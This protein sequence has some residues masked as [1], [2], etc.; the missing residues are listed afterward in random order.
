MPKKQEVEKNKFRAGHKLRVDH[1]IV[2]KKIN[3]SLELSIKDGSAYAA[4]AGFG[5]SYLAPFALAL[6][7]TASQVGILHAIIWIVPSIIQLKASSL[8]RKYSRKRIVTKAVTAEILL[9]IP[10]ILTGLAFYLGF[11]KASWI[12]IGLSGAIYATT[13]IM[14]PIWFSWI[15]SLA[16]ENARGKYFSKRNRISGFV[17]VITMI[18]AALVLDFMKKT[19]ELAGRQLE[20]TLIG[21]AILFSLAILSR[22][23]SLITLKKQYEPRFKLRKKD[24][25]PLREFLKNCTKNSFGKFTIFRA[26]VSF[27]VGIAGPFWTVYMLKDLG[28]PYIWYIAVMSSTIIFRLIFLPALGKISDKF[29]NVNL[30]RISTGAISLVPILWI[31]SIFIPTGLI[32]KLYLIFFVQMISGFGWAGYDLAVNNYVFD[33]VNSQRRSFGMSY[34]TL[35]VGVST[36][37]GA[38]V[39]SGLATLNIQFMNTILFIFAISAVLRILSAIFATRLLHEVRHVKK[40]RYEYLIKEFHPMRGVN[41]EVH[42]LEHIIKKNVHY[43]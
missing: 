43:A 8:L 31:A 41:R 35:F 9:W 33:A 34:M 27:S 20:Y 17:G 22:T 37:I 7:A 23:Y 14:Y 40:F 39:G 15:G 3:K 32:T 38:L 25:F 10:I 5:S 26:I 42:N 24:Y 1:P 18:T 21:F 4:S 11:S 13:A 6:N 19:G 30:M 16:P 29:G 12:L 2:Q 36:A 28:M